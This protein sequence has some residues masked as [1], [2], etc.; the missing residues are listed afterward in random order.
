M[1]KEGERE[2]KKDIFAHVKEQN[3]TD[4]SDEIGQEVYTY[5][6]AFFCIISCSDS[7]ASNMAAPTSKYVNVHTINER[8]RRFCLFIRH[9]SKSTQRVRYSWSLVGTN[10]V[11]RVTI[12]SSAHFHVHTC[13][14]NKLVYVCLISA[15]FLPIMSTATTLGLQ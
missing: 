3:V 12:L 6:S 14:G 9:S 5:L 4:E 10:E 15:Y 7:R 2:R 13:H 8:V 1:S 11:T